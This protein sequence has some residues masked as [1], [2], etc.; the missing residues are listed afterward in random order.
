VAELF[1]DDAIA[2]IHSAAARQDRVYPHAVW[3]PIPEASRQ[4]SID[5]TTAIFH[6]MAG[7]RLTSIENL[8]TY[9]A[10]DDV[11]IEPTGVGPDFAG[12]IFQVVAWDQ[13]AD[14]NF[15][16]NPFATSWETQDNGSATLAATPWSP[17]QV[18]QLAGI[19]AFAHLRDGVPLRP[20]PRWDAGG[21]GYHSQFPEWSSFTG[22]TCPGAARIGQMPEIRARA[23]E[24]VAWRPNQHQEEPVYL[25]KD[26]RAPFAVW[27]SNGVHKSWVNDGHVANLLEDR[28]DI[29]IVS[30]SDDVVIASYGPILGPTPSGFDPYGRKV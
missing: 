11:H 12:R 7:P 24:I 3:A 13:R 17:A 19:A 1:D 5:V 8:R 15:K 28:P 29:D 20:P 30:T 9:V 2:A 16:A 23:V 18:E 10:R 6:S 26:S 4:P 27:L 21:I 22:K 14:C 25:V